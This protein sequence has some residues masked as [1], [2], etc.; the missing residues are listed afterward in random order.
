MEPIGAD[1]FTKGKYFNKINNPY[2][3]SEYKS[4]NTGDTDKYSTV[5]EMVVTAQEKFDIDNH[6]V[7][8]PII[9]DTNNNK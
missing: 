5:F 4:D 8:I 3:K 2:E 1:G 7:I 9:T 6:N